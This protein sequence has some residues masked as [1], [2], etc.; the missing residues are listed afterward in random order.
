MY[1]ASW[2]IRFA[3]GILGLFICQEASAI[4]LGAS[5][6]GKQL[7]WSRKMEHPLDQPVND[8]SPDFTFLMNLGP[9]GIRAMM[10]PAN[11]KAF[12]VMFVFQDAMSPAKGKI[13]KG[14][15]IVGANGK[16]FKDEHG[17]HR[18]A[19]NAS[20]WAGAPFELALA[21]EDSQGK[22]GKLDLAVLQGG[23]KS[24]RTT[25]SI[26]LKPVGRF[27]PTYPWNCPRSDKLLK[28]LCDFLLEEKLD[29][30]P[31]EIQAVLALWASG[32][33]RAIPLVKSK[34]EG[35]MKSIA[36][37]M[38]GS[39]C[40]WM[41]G[42]NGI[43]LGEYYNAFKDKGVMPAVEALVDC[44]ETAQDWKS[45]GFSHRPFPAIE[46]R[47][48]EGGPKGYGSMAAPGGLAM[49]AQSIF[50]ATGLPYSQKAYERTHQAFLKTAGGNADGAIAYGFDAWGSVQIHVDNPDLSKSKRG[51]GFISPVLLKDAGPYKVE[52]W[53]QTGGGWNMEI[54]SPKEFP[55]LEKNAATLHMYDLDKSR[56]LVVA[57]EILPEPTSPYR[58]GSRGGGHNAPVGMGA[59]AHYIGNKDNTSWNYLGM[60]MATC[61]AR[62]PKTLWDGHASSVMHA[63]FGVL[64]AS[65][66]DEK[67]FRDFLD[68]SKTWIIL[69][70]THDGKGLVEQPFGLDR[71]STCSISLDRQ[72]YSHV[73]LLLLSLPKRQ[74]LITGADYAQPA[75]AASTSTAGSGARKTAS[76][77]ASAAY[78]G[79]PPPEAPVQPS[80]EARTL[81][82]ERLVTLNRALLNTLV[83][84]SADGM[85]DPLPISLS[86]TSQ[87]VLL[88][89]ANPDGSLT[90]RAEN[91]QEGTLKFNDLTGVDHGTLA[92]L[93]A[94]LKPA[95]GDAQA[96]AGVYLESLGR[97]SNADSYFEKAGAES[98]QK[99]EKLFD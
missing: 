63:F 66:A 20:G 60:H 82:P 21:I 71:N 16:D 83:K 70:E 8:D 40:T 58:T 17:F 52:K 96:M 93:V 10:E 19:A 11:P 77:F 94:K 28:D 76:Y 91:G 33:K 81:A 46:R 35:L 36:N 79:T 99:L 34:A 30:R 12:K 29:G 69:S 39:M 88:T 3:A 65:R 2:G 75:A 56:R 62:S 92:L 89:A 95:S 53:T 13:N 27:A 50:K 98:R 55:W 64:G 9:T 4:H 67:D 1:R 97:V 54:V 44:Y 32:D 73:A 7:P 68:Y 72:V 45:G 24:K 6:D 5:A 22:D 43:F 15:M 42:Y 85:L 87:R 48:A 80:R 51:I 78:R 90:F 26:Q 31:D 23:D 84:L 57:E 41:W 59:L 47:V 61:C 38:D 86:V 49:L 18:K 14:D 25:V 37:P 74:L